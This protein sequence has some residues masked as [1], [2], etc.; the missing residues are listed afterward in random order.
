MKIRNVGIR[1]RRNRAGLSQKELAEEIGVT[2]VTV[3]RWERMEAES[4]DNA[5]GLTIENHEKLESVFRKY[6][7]KGGVQY[8]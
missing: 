5:V 6:L 1:E 7:D 3:S 8:I 4:D 2:F